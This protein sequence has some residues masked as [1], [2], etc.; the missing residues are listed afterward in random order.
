M[1][2]R[3]IE[4]A[5][6]CHC[7][8]TLVDLGDVC[9]VRCERLPFPV[10]ARPLGLSLPSL[11]R[12]GQHYCPLPFFNTTSLCSSFL[13]LVHKTYRGSIQSSLRR[14][15]P[16]THPSGSE[17]KALGIDFF[18]FFLNEPGPLCQQTTNPLFSHLATTATSNYPP[19]VHPSI[20]RP[21]CSSQ[22]AP[23]VAVT[24]QT[25]S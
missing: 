19:F 25:L 9:Y 20:P 18:F 1:S 15:H 6:S 4:R 14:H 16:G 2:P 7:T 5:P 10:A 3:S 8:Y 22:S 11:D 12:F 13:F 17:R 21:H 24:T 23:P